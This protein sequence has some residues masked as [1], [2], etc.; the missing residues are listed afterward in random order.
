MKKKTE[1]QYS[2]RIQDCQELSL[3]KSVF[4]LPF[5]IQLHVLKMVLVD[6][7]TKKLKTCQILPVLVILSVS[8][9][10]SSSTNQFLKRQTSSTVK[11]SHSRE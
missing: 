10:S 2:I 3:S 11:F 6:P 7:C 1:G 9:L 5:L 8:V 4:I